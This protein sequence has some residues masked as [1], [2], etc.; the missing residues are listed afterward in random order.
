MSMFCVVPMTLRTRIQAGLRRVAASTACAMG[1]AVVALVAS[2]LRATV[3]IAT[4]APRAEPTTAP[5]TAPAD[6]GRLAEL[7]TLVGE[8]SSTEVAV[9]RRL[10]AIRDR[11]RTLDRQISALDQQITVS[12]ANLAQ[13][14][15]EAARLGAAYEEEAREA[16]ALAAE[17]VQSQEEFARVIGELYRGSGEESTS[18]LER[19]PETEALQRTLLSQTYLRQTSRV[20]RQTV[21][22]FVS[23]RDEAYARRDAL[24]AERR[25]AEDARRLAADE[26]AR[27]AGLRDQQG[28]VRRSIAD[29][30]ADEAALLAEV[31][32]QKDVYLQELAELTRTSESIGSE[33]AR[34]QA[35][36]PRRAMQLRRPVVAPVS[37]GYGL[38]MHPL[39][40]DQRLHSGIDYSASSGTPIR[41]AGPGV[42]A[43]AS[44]RGGYGKVIVIDHGN[45]RSTVYAHQSRFAVGVG[46]RVAA[47]DVIGYVGSTGQSTGPHLHFEVRVLGTPTNPASELG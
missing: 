43:I 25:A 35:G 8:A 26:S 22:G 36:Q 29:Q 44:E 7:Q 41:A 31:E 34:R 21:L 23:R 30:E 33:M 1:V 18:F 3:P 45:Q 11:R 32:A 46:T 12:A 19:I 10:R 9:Y 4:A 13:A 20:A 2:E 40:R 15:A 5:G 39:L 38:R 14:D 47:G 28:Q 37:S 24:E 42:V 27:L 17:V 16:A 6:A